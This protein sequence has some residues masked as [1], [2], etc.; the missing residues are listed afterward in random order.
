[1][2]HRMQRVL[3]MLSQAGKILEGSFK[4]P[5]CC[6]KTPNTECPEL[7]VLHLTKGS[8]T[9]KYQKRFVNAALLAAK[10]RSQHTGRLSS[11]QPVING[12][13]SPRIYCQWGEKESDGSR[14]KLRELKKTQNFS[15]ASFK[16]QIGWQEPGERRRN[17]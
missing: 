9:D 7:C 2:H 11:C 16:I 13:L 5:T 12:W 4:C 6:N 17:P 1:M 8:A 14:N 10:T 3:G 15:Q